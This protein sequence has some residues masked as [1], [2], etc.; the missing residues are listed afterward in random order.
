MPP[1]PTPAPLDVQVD[2]IWEC[3]NGVTQVKIIRIVRNSY[4]PIVSMRTE[5]PKL[6]RFMIEGFYDEPYRI[7]ELDLVKLISRNGSP[8][9]HT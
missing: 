9:N 3:R 1:I 8:I 5:V 6:E 2:D 7:H 4:Y